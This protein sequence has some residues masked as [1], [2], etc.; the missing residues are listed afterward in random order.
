MNIAEREKIRKAREEAQEKI[1][2]AQGK[3]HALLEA[4]YRGWLEALE[5]VLMEV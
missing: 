1:K 3:D 5:W 2:T 4:K